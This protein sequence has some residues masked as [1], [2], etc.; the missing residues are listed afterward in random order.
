ML[1]FAVFGL[2]VPVHAQN[3]IER[4]LMPGEVVAAHV[5]IEDDCGSCH[6]PF[7][8][9]SQDSLCLSC[10]KKTKV[11][12]DEL[13]GF[14]GMSRLLTGV[15]CSYCH[16]DHL[17]RDAGI[18][19]LDAALFDHT[20]TD[21][22]LTG[23]HEQLECTDCHSKGKRWADA[24]DTCFGCHVADQPHKGNLGREC[25]SCHRTT[26]WNDRTTF[27]HTKTKFQ[28]RGK[29]GNVAC[30]SCHLGEIYQGL[31][32][33]CDDC[34][35]IQDV[36]QRRFGNACQSCHSE[37][38]WKKAKFDHG[39]AT[40]FPLLGAHAKA[41]CEACHGLSV[42][43]K[44]SMAC[45][46]CHAKQDVHKAQLG[47]NCADCHNDAAWRNDVQFDHGLTAFPLIGLHVVTACE[48]CHQSAAFKDA[49]IA[50]KDCH[51][52]EDVHEGRLTGQCGTC[53]TANGWARVSFDHDSQT[54]F[55]LTGGH[56]KI[57]CYNCHT[58]KN[59]TDASLST[60]CYSCHA[61]QDIH[62]GK[63]G[64]NCGQCHDDLSF[65]TAFIRQ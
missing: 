35:A 42:V 45:F 58:Q 26:I 60:A 62:R 13:R 9:K 51:G 17:G 32:A 34:H 28:L 43:S 21:F 1:L 48:A 47:S 12:V 56:G 24:A 27:D 36:H 18:V 10:H 50:C 20:G 33:T 59:V 6:Q 63:F 29:H 2:V 23:A 46:D 65:S 14:H 55:T 31:P 16:T 4:L 8:Q 53:H 41:T 39:T 11:D 49:S 61:K 52:K 19:P 38:N 7:S 30:K 25:Q 3:T 54:K 44:I 22:P 37:T 40:R 15:L 64:R 57:G 5:S